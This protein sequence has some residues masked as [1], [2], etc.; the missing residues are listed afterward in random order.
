MSELVVKKID[1]ER[2]HFEMKEITVDGIH[3][4]RTN[5]HGGLM[6]TV[7]YD[8][9]DDGQPVNIMDAFDWR[10]DRKPDMDYFMKTGKVQFL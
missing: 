6:F 3:G 5:L 10:A 4:R 7:K 2:Q 9:R 8:S 1:D